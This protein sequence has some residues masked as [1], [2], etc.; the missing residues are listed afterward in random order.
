MNMWWLALYSLL[1]VFSGVLIAGMDYSYFVNKYPTL[2]TPSRRR[3][4]LGAAV[5]T[6]ALGAVLWPIFLP[7]E[8]CLTEFAYHGIWKVPAQY[9]GKQR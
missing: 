7:L 9:Q 6:G 2:D 1:G 3:E 8:F 4:D 5:V